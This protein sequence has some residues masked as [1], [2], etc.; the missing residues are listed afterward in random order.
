MFEGMTTH[1]A[2]G[3]PTLMVNNY[4]GP[5]TVHRHS[6]KAHSTKP[7]VPSKQARPRHPK[8]H[9]VA[10]DRHAVKIPKARGPSKEVLGER[11]EYSRL[12]HA[13]VRIPSHTRRRRQ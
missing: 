10:K 4:N 2:N 3:G 8:E 12:P 5:V 7:K 9:Q 13:H 6:P 11:Y 1:Q